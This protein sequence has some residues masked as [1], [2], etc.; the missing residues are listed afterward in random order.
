LPR[1]R[2]RHG[3]GGAR[4][5]TEQSGK[6]ALAAHGVQISR[7]QIVAVCDAVR[8]AESIGFPVVI[9]ASGAH[10]EHKTEVGG[11]VLNVRSAHDAAQ[12]AQRLAALS[13][14]LLVEEMITDGVA[15]I[16]V[17]VIVDAQFGQVLV[18]GAGGVL[19]ELLRDSVSLLPPWTRQSVGAALERL[20]VARLLAG[21][22]GKPPGD[23]EALERA[24]LGVGRYA[25]EQLDTLIEIDVN[26]VIVRP[27]GSG[28]VAVD[29]MIRLRE[30]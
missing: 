1:R 28:A 4:T 24:V 2:A 26:P 15:E 17:G 18:L 29:A 23:L 3:N 27:L 9:K 14:E 16:L 10:L 13:G 19:T 20:Q 7:G 8:A 22:R 30:E 6:A 12:A 25:A 11:V 21:Y 5:L